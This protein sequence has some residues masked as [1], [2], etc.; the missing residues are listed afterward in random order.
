VHVQLINFRLSGIDDEGYARLCDELAPAFASLPGLLSKVWL[1]D[2]DGGTYGGLYLWESAG[3][4]ASFL[5]SDLFAAVRAHPNLSEVTVRD[6]G[7]LPGPTA[8]T[9]RIAAPA[10]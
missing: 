2:H 6:W 5:D 4:M 8:M 1:A 10:S 7:V 9:S 3:A